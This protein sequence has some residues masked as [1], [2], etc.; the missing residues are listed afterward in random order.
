MNI[1][2]AGEFT[3][4]RHLLRGQPRGGSLQSRLEAFYAPQAGDYD[5]FRERLL[6][7]RSAL[8]DALDLQPGHAVVE[9]GAGTGW[10]TRYYDA[11]LPFLRQLWLV[12]LCPSLLA[13]AAARL[14]G[15]PRVQVCQ[16][17]AGSFALAAPVDRVYLSYA[18]TMMPSWEAVIDNAHRMLR[19]GGLIGLVD[20]F[21]PA[22]GSGDGPRVSPAAA[23]FW[24]RWFAHDGVY[25]GPER[26]ARLHERF[27]PVSCRQRLGR[28]PF[29]PGLRVPWYLFIGRRRG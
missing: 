7:G 28:V 21:L 19:P 9:L 17:D 22:P 26:L 18:L 10:N 25:L 13:R 27:E 3:V 15:Q 24:R 1:P 11:L 4:L 16:A 5:R 14:A 12:D 8:I 2:L 20:F 29:L 6:H 23:W